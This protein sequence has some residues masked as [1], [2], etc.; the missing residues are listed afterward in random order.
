[1]AKIL[2]VDEMRAVEK[3]AD[4]AGHSYAH[5]MEHAGHSVSRWVEHVCG[6]LQG[7]RTV[8]LCGVG[9]N[10]GDGLVAAHWLH[11]GGS[12][13]EVFLAKA[14]PAND[15][16]AARLVAEGLALHV[17]RDENGYEELANALAAADVFLDALL[18]TGTRLP[19]KD[20][21]PRLLAA[22][23]TGLAAGP[24]R[25]LVVAVDC[26]SGVDCDSG[27]A[28]AETVRADLTVTLAAAK[29]GL[30]RFP[31]AES[32]GRLVIGDIGLPVGF[33]PL[34]K[35]SLLM[36]EPEL[37]R[38]WIPARPRSAHKGTFGRVVVVAGS[39]NYPGAALLSGEAAYRVGAGLVTLATPAPVY[40]VIVPRLP[41]ATWMI[42]PDEMGVM[43]ESA[44]E[45]LE[46]E[47]GQAQAMVFGPGFGVEKAT[48]GFVRRLMGVEEA[49][50]PMRMGFGADHS[51]S[52]A[53]HG[54]PP[55]VIDADGL[56]LLAQVDKWWTHVPAGSIVTPHPG[57][58]A[59]LSGLSVNEVQADRIG[60]AQ[61]C[62]REWGV[63]VVLKGAFSVVA[64][65][66]G[67]TAVEP[68][69]TAALARAGTGDVLT[70]AIAGLVAQ[71]LPAWHA[72]VLGAYVH[73][74]AGELAEEELQTAAA[75][76]AGDVAQSLGS[77]L[78]ELNEKAP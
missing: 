9:N 6:G 66:T 75:V 2:T 33:A 68:F 21:L 24:R 64:A 17:V 74:R 36:A 11:H 26:P 7:Q 52:S 62:A 47:M 61:R 3:Q 8:V 57:E 23:A 37:L 25:P 15:E 43:A 27:A 45:V 60:L 35:A 16:N 49:P 42:L 5:M 38:A 46:R 1:M 48:A 50:H 34:E 69:A 13:V 31:A 32:V 28:A 18:G 4:A 29:A 65:P 77:A 10:G 58:M 67:E 44:V 20:P 59:I 53:A 40:K 41:E 76:L 14:R 51:A 78:A 73:G 70:G 12:E 56:K 30:L 63:V 55:M 19:L 71:G 22:V 54:W 72:A 39:I